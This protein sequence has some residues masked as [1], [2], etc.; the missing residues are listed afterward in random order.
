MDPHVSDA[1]KDIYNQVHKTHGDG[2]GPA[3]VDVYDPVAA[4]SPSRL[5]SEQANWQVLSTHRSDLFEA[6]VEYQ[7]EVDSTTEAVDEVRDAAKEAARQLPDVL[8]EDRSYRDAPRIAHETE[9][10]SYTTTHSP[11]RFF[12]ELG[13]ALVGVTDGDLGQYISDELENDDLVEDWD[14]TYADWE[15]ELQATAE[16]VGVTDALEDAYA[17]GEALTHAA[18]EL[19]DELEKD[20]ETSRSLSDRLLGR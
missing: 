15:E 12:R 7:D 4:G 16:E 17:Q 10:G 18:A 3:Q 20:L 11:A 6:I 19:F 14:E 5:Q 2:Y 8:T 13:P 9:D 1:V